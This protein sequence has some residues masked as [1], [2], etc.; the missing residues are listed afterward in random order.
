M[1]TDERESLHFQVDAALLFELGEQLVARPA[2]A[3]AELIKNGYDADAKKIT[4]TFDRVSQPGGT[5]IVE[6]D[7]DGMTYE[8]LRTSW[9]RIATNNKVANPIS[10]KY[11]RVRTGAKGV[12]RFA[13][14]KM[15]QRLILTTVA[16]VSPGQWEKT[17]A[18]FDWD[19]FR[20]GMDLQSIA[21]SY[22][23]ETFSDEITTGTTLVLHPVRNAWDEAAVSEVQQ[24]LASLTP[25]FRNVL[26]PEDIRPD[27]DS[28]DPGCAIQ[29]VAPEFPD[30]EGEVSE[31]FL[32][33]AVGKFT[34]EVMAD[35]SPRYTLRF[36]DE[37]TTFTFQPEV[38]LPD[39]IGA[40]AVVYWYPFRGGAFEGVPSVRRRAK[41]FGGIKVYLDNYRIFP[42]GDPGDDWLKLDYDKG[43]RVT[44]AEALLSKF[45]P[46][47][48]SRGML[49]LPGN[50]NVVGGVFVSRVRN[51]EIRPTIGRE[52]VLE[53]DA[54]VQMRRLVRL[55]IDWMVLQD[56]QHQLDQQRAEQQRRREQE[57]EQ[58]KDRHS[59]Q[60]AREVSAT[61]EDDKPVQ[62]TSTV[63]K[64]AVELVKEEL[65]RLSTP[66]KTTPIVQQLEE[67]QRQVEE[68]EAEQIDKVSMVR[69]LAS[70]GTAIAIFIHQ[71]RAVIDGFHRL[72]AA[73][74][75][76][77]W[78]LERDHIR[79]QMRAWTQVME[80]QAAQ[81]GLLLGKDARKRRRKLFLRPIVEEAFAP[82]RHYCQEQGIELVNSVPE[83][84]RTPSLFEAELHALLLNTLTN[85]IKAVKT[86]PIRR[87]EA[88][89]SYVGRHLLFE[90]RDT[91]SGVP[92]ERR[93]KVFQP[94]ETTSESDPV[95]GVGT[96]LGL[97]I[98]RDIV[99][100]HRGTARFIDVE[101]PWKTCIQ[102]AIPMGVDD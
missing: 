82:L 43:R 28:M 67:M 15:A 24:D 68:R 23:R 47:V 71:I 25:P 38:R 45:L 16:Q 86:Q 9:M 5:I 75:H 101:E 66:E 40:T 53:N 56:Q 74:D 65:G 100:S 59:D 63:V 8:V 29:I 70:A 3:L 92:V 62:T 94:F 76:D 26:R 79:S 6:D 35:G 13:T 102:L 96:G 17:V 99:M 7:G 52:R 46:E 78:W 60:P 93:E 44:T 95:L 58:A 83:N 91:G 32:S 22:Q 61:A 88:V 19:K 27:D 90:L 36:R 31:E 97:A 18:E 50:M 20:P 12:G 77:S 48:A 87:I 69:V 14:R 80:A 98:V 4:I 57:T 85:A 37:E 64:V 89:A 54:F 30:L 33:A 81:L 11:G 51:P 55:G 72:T 2:V 10:P 84:L 41:S 39:L 42:Y 73:L 34:V 49:S 1:S 21:M